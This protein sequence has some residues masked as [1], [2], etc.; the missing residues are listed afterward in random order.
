MADVRRCVRQ[1]C[2]ATARRCYAEEVRAAARRVFRPA[3][4][5]VGPGHSET[6]YRN[7]LALELRSLTPRACVLTEAV[8]PIVYRGVNVGFCRADIVVE[9]AGSAGSARRGCSVLELKQTLA[10][11][12]GSAADVYKW[13]LQAAKYK[14]YFSAS[15]A[16]LVVFG[17]DDAAVTAV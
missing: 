4:G 5:G 2:A 16:M 1:L 12:G 3:A 11:T 15:E 17:R 13:T 10:K 14:L 7:A 9:H 6:V 8:E